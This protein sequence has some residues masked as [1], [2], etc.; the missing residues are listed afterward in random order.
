MNLFVAK[1]R[2][3]VKGIMTGFDRIVFKGSI[4]PLMHAKGAM[5]FCS[6]HGIRNKDFKSWA[7]AQTSQ[8]VESAQRYAQEHCGCG[9]EPIASTTGSRTARRNRSTPCSNRTRASMRRAV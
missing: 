8:V 2:D 5:S 9:I 3:I 7:M 4:L 6:T 1:F